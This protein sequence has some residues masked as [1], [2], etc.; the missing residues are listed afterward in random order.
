VEVECERAKVRALV[1][2]S[3]SGMVTPA[4]TLVERDGI[5]RGL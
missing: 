5:L 4:R 1:M 3:V 2:S